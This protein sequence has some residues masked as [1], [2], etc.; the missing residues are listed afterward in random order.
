M[1]V[2]KAAPTG[3]LLGKTWFMHSVK[4]YVKCRTN[5]PDVYMATRVDLKKKVLRKQVGTE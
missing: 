4:Y 1:E 2:T 3:G 5:D